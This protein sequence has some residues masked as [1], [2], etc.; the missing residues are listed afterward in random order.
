MDDDVTVRL[1]AA[2]FTEEVTWHGFAPAVEAKIGFIGPVDE[3]TGWG[4]W[5]WIVLSGK[6]NASVESTI[7]KYLF[8]YVKKY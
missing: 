2:P 7:G 6:T 4:S 5:Y 1:R 8:K 3:P